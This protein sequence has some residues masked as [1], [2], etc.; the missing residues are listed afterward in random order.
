MGRTLGFAGLLIVVVSGLYIY[1]KNVTSITSGG[2]NPKT[3]VDVTGVNNDLLAIANAE[4]RY[5]AT[6]AKY[7]SLG[8]LQANG[9]IQVPR[10]A[11]Y[12][13]SAEIG[14][15]GF[16]IIAT[17]SG[18]DPKAPNHISVDETMSLKTY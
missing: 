16:K 15:S 4:R 18:P 1:A 17:Y 11:A 8:E 9:D 14:D 10:R 6:N 12:N 3:V 13:Y 5:W 7:G 2:T